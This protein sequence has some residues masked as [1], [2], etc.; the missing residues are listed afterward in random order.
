M[1]TDQVA[2]TLESIPGVE[3]AD[4]AVAVN[5]LPGKHFATTT[6]TVTPDGDASLGEVLSQAASVVWAELGTQFPT[7]RFEV[8]APVAG[9]SSYQMVYLE[10]RKAELPFHDDAYL[11]RSVVLST[12][13]LAAVAGVAK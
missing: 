1:N 5:G 10:D 9:S 11:G 6:L 3:A 12:D 7:Y 8:T 13:E 4:V 2:T